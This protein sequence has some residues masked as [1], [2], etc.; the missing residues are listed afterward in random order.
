M[1]NVEIEFSLSFTDYFEGLFTAALRRPLNII[2]NIVAL[3]AIL[4][5]A[6]AISY[7]YSQSDL[8]FII[9]YIYLLLIIMVFI[10][11]PLIIA[12]RYSQNKLMTTSQKWIMNA[13]GIEFKNNYSESKSTW[14]IINEYLESKNLLIMKSSANTRLIH[15]LP[16]R[17]FAD[18]KEMDI[19][20]GYIKK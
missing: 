19:I 10:I 5:S 6:C 16:K 18:K 13:D 1:N 20:K 2:G 12:F 17:A 15:I 7:Y 3:F 4:I 8:L 14:S 11:N 9:V